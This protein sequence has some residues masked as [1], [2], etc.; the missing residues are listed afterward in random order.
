MSNTTIKTV[1][2]TTTNSLEDFFNIES[3]STEIEKKIVETTN[4]VE[5]EVY[6]EKDSEI[7]RDFQEIADMA[8]TGFENLMDMV[9]VSDKKTVA[10]LSEVANQYL[11]TALNA[12]ESKAKLKLNKEKLKT[13]KNSSKTTNNLIITR[14]EL[15]K[16]L[17]GDNSNSTANEDGSTFEEEK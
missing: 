9:D 13:A 3:G 4:L 11:N 12:V 5:T 2:K 17:I 8:K 7:E 6:D 15:L 1:T 16:K 14:E 10:R